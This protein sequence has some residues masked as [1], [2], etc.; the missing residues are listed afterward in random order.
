MTKYKFK[1]FMLAKGK[2]GYI[3]HNASL[4]YHL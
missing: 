4:R 1:S 3:D 2:D